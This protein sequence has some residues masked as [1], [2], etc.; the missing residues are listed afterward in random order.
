MIASEKLTYDQV[1][2]GLLDGEKQKEL[3][4]QDEEEDFLDEG[5]SI[6]N[7]NVF[8]LHFCS[9]KFI[10][11]MINI[12]FN[13]VS[14][15]LSRKFVI[16]FVSACTKI[17]FVTSSFIYFPESFLMWFFGCFIFL[18]RLWTISPLWNCI[19]KPSI[20]LNLRHFNTKSI[21][22]SLNNHSLRESTRKWLSTGLETSCMRTFIWNNGLFK[23]NL[24][25]TAKSI[26]IVH[27]RE[28]G[29]VGESLS[30]S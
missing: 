26:K 21:Y 9:Q 12:F 25:D 28:T 20:H 7:E 24:S 5:K 2:N 22:F 29:T 16:Q 8:F 23:R 15:P 13:E 11:L 18:I 10:P 3:L 30:V 6:R 14:V 17:W 27:Q 4:S 1:N 19:T